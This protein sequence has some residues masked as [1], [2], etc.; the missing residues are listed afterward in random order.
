MCRQPLLTARAPSRACPKTSRVAE[1]LPYHRAAVVLRRASSVVVCAHVRPDG[2]AIGST[3]GLTLA[4]RAAGI[5][6]I[7]T[8]ADDEPAP[9]SYAFLPGFGLFVRASDLEAPEVFVA[10]DTPVPERLGLGR[11]LMDNA[12]STILI[13]HHPD[14]VSYADHCICDSRAAATAELVWR[15]MTALDVVPTAEIALP[16]YVGLITDTGRFSYDNTTPEALRAAAQMIESG[17]DP[18]EASRL[19]YQERTRG[20]LELEAR[21]LS[22]LVVA[23]DGHVAWTFLTDEDFDS[24]GA[25]PEDAE[26]L[27]DAVRVIGGIDVA[28]L[29]RQRGTEV[30]GN[31]RAKTGADVS[32][33]ARAFG[34]GGHRAAAGFTVEDSTVSEVV[35]RVLSLLPGGSSA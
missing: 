26:H 34:G 12:E 8:L 28:L 1:V 13:D 3:L 24:T 9:S 5:P 19:V 15:F 27:P 33:V 32:A 4:L 29:L 30:R 2:D 18:A 31:L 14:A 6:A 11:P 17:V 7:P 21:V 35:A 16:L 25:R 10:L 20:S 23:N 22:R